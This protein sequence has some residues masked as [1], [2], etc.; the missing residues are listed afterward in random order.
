MINK[1]YEGKILKPL[2][3]LTFDVDFWNLFLEWTFEEENPLEFLKLDFLLLKVRIFESRN[4]YIAFPYTLFIR[5]LT[6]YVCEK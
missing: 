3:T 4:S 2:K 1:T 5:K 6:Y